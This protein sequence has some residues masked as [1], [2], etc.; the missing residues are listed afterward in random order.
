MKQK[1]TCYLN[2]CW[3][4][5]NLPDYLLIR[6][7]S[8]QALTINFGIVGMISFLGIQ[9]HSSRWPL[10]PKWNLLFSLESQVAH[11]HEMMNS[12]LEISVET[13]GLQGFGWVGGVPNGSTRM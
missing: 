5:K 12:R 1:I 6:E 8:S 7:N 9:G 3:H 13:T 2:Y 10:R 4:L 11:L